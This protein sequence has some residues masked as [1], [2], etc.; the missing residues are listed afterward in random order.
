MLFVFSQIFAGINYAFIMASYA[1]KDRKWLLIFSFLSLIANAVSF[2]LLS[3]WSGLAMIVIAIV[4]NIIFLIQH[5]YNKSDKITNVDWVVL[6]GLTA[7]MA[8]LAGFTYNGFLSLFSVF[9]SWLYTFS[10][11]QKNNILYNIL[12]IFVD[13]CWLVYD[14]FIWSPVSVACE[15]ILLVF[16]ISSL[17]YKKVKAKK[18]KVLENDKAPKIET[19]AAE[20]VDINAE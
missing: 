5:K 1:V 8:V 3:A 2:I 18:S 15:S 14:V 19:E 9:A 10:V 11:W 6:I 12:G 20:S 4:R 7:A 13:A 17:I 16:V